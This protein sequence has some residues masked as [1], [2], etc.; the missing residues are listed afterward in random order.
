MPCRRVVGGFGRV[1]PR[2]DALLAHEDHVHA[3]A[4]LG[5]LEGHAPRLAGLL[6]AL[7]ARAVGLDIAGAVERRRDERVA[8]PGGVLPVREVVLGTAAQ[9]EPA[10]AVDV[11]LVPED[12]HLNGAQVLVETVAEPV[13][14][15]KKRTTFSLSLKVSDKK[16]LKK[17]A[18]ERETTIAA[19]VHEWVQ[20]HSEN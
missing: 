8:R 17:M 13:A 15:D 1:L 3:A 2:R 9:R 18:A 12:V 6:D 11:N 4:A 7:Q 14:E 16:A 19:I 20:E 5:H 10:W